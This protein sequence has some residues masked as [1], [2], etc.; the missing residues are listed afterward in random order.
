[1]GHKFLCCSHC[2]MQL[3]WKSCPH[4]SVPRSSP[5][6]YSSLLTQ[7]IINKLIIQKVKENCSFKY[8][9]ISFL[10]NQM[11]AVYGPVWMLSSKTLDS[12]AKYV[13]QNMTNQTGWV[14]GQ[15][16]WPV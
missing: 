6:L 5:S 10:F 12:T 15:P 13:Y 9:M 7:K 1:M 11:K 2:F 16:T 8:W 14:V 3:W 4:S